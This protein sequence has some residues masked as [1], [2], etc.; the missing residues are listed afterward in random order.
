MRTLERATGIAAKTHEGRVDKAGAPYISRPL[1]MMLRLTTP[2]DMISAVLHDVVEGSGLSLEALR[3]E[4][5]SETI[6]GAIDSVAR[7]LEEPYEAFVLRAASN[8][9]GRR[10]KL[11]DLED[12]SDLS[13]ISNPEPRDYERIEKYLRA[14]EMVR[15]L[16]GISDP[17]QGLAAGQDAGTA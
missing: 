14:I 16:E 4:G 6:I 12:N 9:I 2:D 3:A 11:A 17:E 1:R 10:L 15:A 5:F 7:R 13:R 8:P